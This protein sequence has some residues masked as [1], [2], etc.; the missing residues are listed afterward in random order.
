MDTKMHNKELVKADIGKNMRQYTMCGVLIVLTVAFAILTNGTFVSA[1]N[2]SN[3]FLQTSALAIAAIGV[4][5]VLVAGHIDLSIG[6]CVGLTGAL[7][8]TLMVNA[9]WSTVPT[10]LLTLVVGALIGCWQGFWVAYRKVPSF[11]VTL[12]GSLVFRGIVLGITNGA[13][14]APCTDA[15]KAIGQNYIPSLFADSK[16]A[17]FND[18]AII[19]GLLICFIYIAESLRRRRSRR[20]YEL[21]VIPMSFQIVKF[22]VLCVIALGISLLLSVNNGIPYALL[23]VMIL[24][25][26]FSVVSTMTPFGRHIYSIGGN[27]DAA[28][29]SGIN[30]KKTI[31]L[32]FVI[33]GIMSAKIGR[34]H[35]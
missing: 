10:V 12:A 22:V 33:M 28:R 25:V 5:L 24:A 3:I 21:S 7:A 17:G 26:I 20:E 34:A 31:F 18:T 29:L 13:T 4:S 11:I 9:H 27:P 19:F 32:L 30:I 23:I 2:V 1:R 14:I 8:A 6:S 16:T 15:F 35:V